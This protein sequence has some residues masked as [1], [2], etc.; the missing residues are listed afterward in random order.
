MSDFY[1]KIKLLEIFGAF[2]AGFLY[3]K[4]KKKKKKYLFFYLRLNEINEWK[5]EWKS[6]HWGKESLN[7][8]NINFLIRFNK[9]R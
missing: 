2:F 7:L 8:K 3:S 1:V 6:K 4:K 5:N 9:A